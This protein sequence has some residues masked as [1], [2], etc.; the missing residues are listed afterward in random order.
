[1]NKTPRPIRARK[2]GGPL[3][4]VVAAPGASDEFHNSKQF[5]NVAINDDQNS[6]GPITNHSP[7]IPRRLDLDWPGG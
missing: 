7:V 1:M 4:V 2:G 6:C 3:F 5:P